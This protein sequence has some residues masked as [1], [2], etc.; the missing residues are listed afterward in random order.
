MSDCSRLSSTSL[1]LASGAASAVAE[2]SLS[3]S[4]RTAPLLSSFA[5]LLR[6]LLV[7]VSLAVL[8]ALRV[9]KVDDDEPKRRFRVSSEQP[10]PRVSE[11]WRGLTR[12]DDEVIEDEVAE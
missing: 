4:T 6:L 10:A 9:E 1:S 8:L 2:G 11:G 3:Y 7:A 12:P 5:L